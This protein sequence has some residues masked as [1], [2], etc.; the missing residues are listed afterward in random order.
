MV[1]PRSREVPKSP[2]K[3]ESGYRRRASLAQQTRPIRRSR[4][5]NSG[6]SYECAQ[7]AAHDLS[8]TDAQLARESAQEAKVLGFEAE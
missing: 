4:R 6:C 2:G 1:G 3:G 8:F 7:P 5:A